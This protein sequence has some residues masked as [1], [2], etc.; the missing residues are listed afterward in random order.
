MERGEQH[1]QSALLCLFA[2]ARVMRDQTRHRVRPTEFTQVKRAVDRV[3]LGVP[4]GGGVADVV[5]PSGRAQSVQRP[6][7]HPATDKVVRRVGDGSD[8][9]QPITLIGLQM[10]EQPESLAPEWR[11]LHGRSVRPRWPVGASSATTRCRPPCRAKTDG[12]TSCT[13]GSRTANRIGHYSVAVALSAVYD[14]PVASATW[15]PPVLVSDGSEYR[16]GRTGAS[17]MASSV[18]ELPTRDVQGCARD[19]A[20]CV[21]EQERDSVGEFFGL[22]HACEG[23]LVDEALP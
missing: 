19:V 21:R 9:Q 5:Q 1:V 3:M 16:R 11:Q 17:S 15:T 20:G 12:H 22:A 10:G 4:Q 14:R 13:G 23:H 6:R 8:M 7:V 18:D 2:S